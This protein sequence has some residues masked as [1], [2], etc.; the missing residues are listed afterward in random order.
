MKRSFLVAATVALCSLPAAANAQGLGILGGWSYSQVPSTN[1]SGAGSYTANSG[2]AIGVGAETGGILGFGINGMYAQRGFTNSTPGFGQ[3]VS[4]IDVPVYLRVA[5]P[6]PVVVPFALAGPQVSFQ[7]NCDEGGGVSCPT[8]NDKTQWSAIAGL[9]VR[10]PMIAG[11]SVQGRY[12]YALKD[13]NYGTIN[14]Q[15]NYRQRSFEILLGL[16]F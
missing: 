11:L 8:G 3:K 2:F 12:V 1:A 13:L 6:N 9:G 16:G 5:I 15:S 4:Y 10:F 7:V 14:N